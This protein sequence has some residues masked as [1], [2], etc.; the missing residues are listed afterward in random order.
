MYIYYIYVYVVFVKIMGIQ[1][2]TIELSQ[3]RPWAISPALAGRE[4][5]R[6]LSPSRLPIASRG[7]VEGPSRLPSSP[8]CL[9]PI[10]W[11]FSCRRL[12]TREH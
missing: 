1:L 3:A 10:A 11:W 4:C 2:N 9:I 12:E 7:T 5:R 6:P 8:H